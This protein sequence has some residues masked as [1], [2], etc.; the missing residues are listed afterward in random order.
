M[1]IETPSLHK[2]KDPLTLR[3]FFMTRMQTISLESNQKI[4]FASDFHLGTPSHEASLKRERKIVRWLTHIQADAQVIFLVGDLFDFWHEYKTVVPK[5][6]VRFFGKLAELSDAGIQIVI[7]TGNH[8]L[9]M[10]DYFQTELNISVFHQPIQIAVNYPN[11]SK[12]YLFYIGHG[13]GLGPGDYGYKFLKKIFRNP[14]CQWLF[15]Q[16]H[17]DLGIRLATLWSQ[18]SRGANVAKNEEHFLGE[19]RE[20]LF[21]FCQSTEATQHHD[22]Y[23][24]GHRHLPLNLPVGKHGSCYINLGEWFSGNCHYAVFDGQFLELKRFE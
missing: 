22:Y 1:V 17:P 5:G 18:Q 11:P 20:L 12:N 14:V 13:D 6:F 2:P 9:W 15:R 3:V 10:R 16:V 4:Y 24:F 23:I 21:Q 7:F 19:D 8:D